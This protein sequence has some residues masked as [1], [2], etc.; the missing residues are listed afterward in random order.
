MLT[1]CQKDIAQINEGNAEMVS[2]GVDAG[3][4][5][6]SGVNLPTRYIMAVYSDSDYSTAENVFDSNT[7]NTASSATGDFS[8]VLDRTKEY[9]CL[10]WADV[11]GDAIYDVSDLKDVSLLS[12]QNP[13]ES[14]SN[15]LY[16]PAEVASS[17][18]LTLTRT[19]AS[20]NLYETSILSADTR[21]SISFDQATSFNVATST[22][23]SSEN[24]RTEYVDIAQDIN[25]TTTSVLLNATP[26]YVFAPKDSTTIK[27][28]VI[29]KDIVDGSF[30]VEDIPFQA[31]NETNISG[32][33]TSYAVSMF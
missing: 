15:T 5:R 18:L 6:A 29:N 17:Y 23:N 20:V 21:F 31:N 12:G 11:S 4:T 26:F 30:I 3:E 16:I 14:W 10:F 9:Y 25:G 1:G 28:V 33:Y 2:I 27:D 13:V 24:Y 19:V 7:S 22:V 8:V 32:H